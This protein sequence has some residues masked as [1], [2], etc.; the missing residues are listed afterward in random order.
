[1]TKIFFDCEFTG[2]QKNTDLISIGIIDEDGNS[3]YAEFNDYKK[4]LVTDWIQKNVIDNLFFNHVHTI[5]H[6][7]LLIGCKEHSMK[8][9]KEEV[10]EAI[11]QFISKYDE[12]EIWSDCLAYDWVLFCDLFGHALN[13]PS[14]VYYIPFDICTAFKMKGIDPD[15]SREQF[16]NVDDIGNKHNA[17]YDAIVIKACYENLMS[18]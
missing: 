16:A 14:N 1:M 5:E 15:I 2:L 4:E 11:R 12:V 10:A 6:K 8:G 7:H 17:L 9:N 13:I 18:K 3:F